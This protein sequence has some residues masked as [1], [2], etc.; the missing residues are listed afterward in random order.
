MSFYIL[1][2][3]DEIAVIAGGDSSLDLKKVGQFRRRRLQSNGGSREASPFWFMT[4]NTTYT[5]KGTY[6]Q[7]K[8]VLLIESFEIWTWAINSLRS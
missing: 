6:A 3:E 2:R 7:G 1:L 8:S 4:T 5:N